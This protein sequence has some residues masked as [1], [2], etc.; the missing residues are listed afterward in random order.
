MSLAE[1]Q[2]AL[3]PHPQFS[4]ALIQMRQNLEAA[5]VAGGEQLNFVF[6]IGDNLRIY[7]FS[8][9]PHEFLRHEV[10]EAH[11]H[12]FIAQLGGNDPEKMAEIAALSG[13]EVVIPSDH[14]MRGPDIQ[15]KLAEA[16]GKPLAAL[17]TAYFAKD[18]VPGKWYEIGVKVSPI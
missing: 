16:M 6:Q 13:A 2:K 17:S 8:A 7:L 12:V 10:M 3:P 18:I 14:D 15:H 5:G 1:L 4:P 9:A 11:P